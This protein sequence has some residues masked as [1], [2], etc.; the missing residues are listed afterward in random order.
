MTDV[1]AIQFL[2]DYMIHADEQ[3]LA[4]LRTVPDQGF[5]LEQNISLGSLE[6]LVDH[7]IAGQE[8]WLSRFQQLDLPYPP[9]VSAPLDQ[10]TERWAQT[11]GRLRSFAAAQTTESLQKIIRARTR[12]GA[13]F[14]LPI[15]AGMLHLADHSTYH[16]GQLNSMIKLAGGTPSGV[17]LTR[18]AMQR[19]ADDRA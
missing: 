15:W 7:V 2:W 12:L 10:V 19:L 11:H 14:E 6:K 16:R 18:F 1:A 17:M 9:F 13:A 5:R 8:A 4:A 3:I